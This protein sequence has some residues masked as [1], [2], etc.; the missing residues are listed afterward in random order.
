MCTSWNNGVMAEDA[1]TNRRVARTHRD[2][3]VAVRELFVEAGWDAITHQR[4]AERAGCG[5][6]TVY[7]HFPNRV[8]LLAHAGN[9]ADVHHAPVTGDVRVDLV[10]ELLSFRRELFQGILGQI[11]AAVVERAERDPKVKPI[12]DELISVGSQQTRELVAQ[13]VAEG[14]LSSDLT[15]DD[16]TANLCGPLVFARLFQDRQPTEEAVEHLVNHSLGMAR[17]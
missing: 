15:L 3:A 1:P 2:I 8:S 4:V 13:A 10:A 17:R 14:L 5:R 12:R 7:R 9:F 11:I 6:N 16:H